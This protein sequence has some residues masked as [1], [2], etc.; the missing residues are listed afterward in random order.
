MAVQYEG[1]DF[2]NYDLERDNIYELA[3]GVVPEI[4][5]AAD[6]DLR[7]EPAGHEGQ[8]EEPAQPAEK[9]LRGLVGALGPDKELQK[10]IGRVKEALGEDALEVAIEWEERAGLMYPVKRA[11]VKDTSIPQTKNKKGVIN[12][13]TASWMLRR[14]NEAER[15]D[16]EEDIEEIVL[17]AGNREMSITEH[18]LVAT[19]QR[20]HGKLPT[21]ADFLEKYVADHL[22]S[23]GHTVEPVV[24]ADSTSAKEVFNTLI[25]E[26]PDILNNIVVV[27]ANAP[28]AIQA[29]GQLRLGARRADAAF[30]SNGD[31]LFMQSDSFPLARRSESKATHQ[32]PFSGLSQLLRNALIL[33]QNQAGISK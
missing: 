13:G 17:A 30:D 29:A 3:G 28:N 16:P 26:R 8:L 31:Q 7:E 15:L 14:R 27:I 32:D 19:Y 20:K 10:N 11:Y 2:S 9:P 1:P 22:R 5:A 25:A 23:L 18:P 6:F 12:G 4:A 24:R 33:Y 21:E